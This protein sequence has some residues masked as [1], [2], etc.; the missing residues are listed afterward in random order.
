MLV[1]VDRV[2]LTSYSPKDLIKAAADT[3][4]QV[5]DTTNLTNNKEKGSTGDSPA[6]DLPPD[7][8]ANY[9][10]E[11]I[12]TWIR[13]IRRIGKVRFE[14]LTKLK[15]DLEYMEGFIKEGSGPS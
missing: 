8:I 15:A 2:T 9:I 4:W 3:I 7:S 1:G 10:V 5:R 12:E 13:N 6:G 11:S 14:D